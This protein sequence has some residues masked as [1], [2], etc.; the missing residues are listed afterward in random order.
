MPGNNVRIAKRRR[1]RSNRRRIDIRSTEISSVLFLDHGTALKNLHECKAKEERCAGFERTSSISCNDHPG[2]RCWS[3]RF[4]CMIMCGEHTF[5]FT[6]VKCAPEKIAIGLNSTK[7]VACTSIIG[8]RR[9]MPDSKNMFDCSIS[10][11]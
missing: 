9:L 3:E 2:F 7:S 6:V 4:V 8:I 5:G 10:M 11:S 1:I